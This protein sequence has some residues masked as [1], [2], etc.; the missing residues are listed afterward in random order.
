MK[1]Y[2]AEA[3]RLFDEVVRKDAYSGRVGGKDT[4]AMTERLLLGALEKFV[5]DDYILHELVEKRPA[6]VI[7]ALLHVGVYALLDIDNVPDY[8]VISECVEAAGTLGKRQAGSFVNAVLRKVQRREYALPAPG[9]PGYAAVHYSKPDFFIKLL[10]D[11][12]GKEKAALILEEPAPDGV[13]I[14]VNSRLCTPETVAGILDAHA[15]ERLPSEVGGMCLKPMGEVRELF[16]EG[17]ITYQSPSSMLAV[18]ALAPADGARILDLCAAPGGKAVYISE[19]CPSSEV[20]ACELHPHRAELIRAYADRMH[21]GNITVRVQD[22]TQ[23]VPEFE[24]AFDFVLVDAPCS[25]LGTYRRHPDVLLRKSLSDITALSE[26]QRKLLARAA[27]Y[28]K[29]GGVLVYSTCTLTKEENEQN[30]E[31]IEH[32]LGLKPEVMP[33]PFDNDGRYTVL[34]HGIWDGF[35]VA[36]FRA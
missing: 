4:P 2:F 32:K 9:S 19:L 6:P 7:Y 33:I 22:G 3:A 11:R 26:L 16:K 17:M 30:A 31:F 5:R 24:E 14:R 12:F 35:F 8:A 25:C 21:A 10:E 1:K 13:H 34:P 27:S 29:S 23:R 36:R 18:Q 20:V 15:T 28:L